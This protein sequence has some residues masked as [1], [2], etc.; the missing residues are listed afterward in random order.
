MKSV[1]IIESKFNNP[2]FNLAAEE[3]FLNNN[4]EG[5]Q[6]LF[7]WR[8]EPTIVV[9]KHQNPWVECDVSALERDNIHLARRKSGGG[10]VYQ[11]LGNSIF[12]FLSPNTSF[13]KER[14][15]S[16]LIDS[17]EL[18][19]VTGKCEVSGRNDIT[20]DGKKVSGSA[21]KVAEKNAIHH[22]TMLISAD[23]GALAKYLSP[24]KIKLEAK[25]VS[26]VRSRVTNLVE[27]AHPDRK[28]DH[29]AFC[30][31]LAKSFCTSYG[32][33]APE[34]EIIDES[35]L[36]KEPEIKRIADSLESWDWRFGST[37]H[38]TAVYEGR[39]DLGTLSVNLN[40]RNGII[41]DA[42]IFSDCLYTQFVEEL[43][44]D[45]K[46]A[47]KLE[48]VAKYVRKSQQNELFDAWREEF[49]NWF[50]SQL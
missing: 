34:I 16:I 23:L 4:P 25:G 29:E 3:F 21:Y 8:N 41:E 5:V 9:G 7:L 48:N 2:F 1:R 50:E 6:T 44:S 36:E 22:G 14:N 38:F 35:F 17:L 32:V 20:C 31:A 39:L 13:D 18:L 37:P 45:V 46:N 30:G 24:S 33:K 12:T 47:G 43:E 27:Y 49:I 28:I 26:S 40:M 11:D 42:K 15:N 10:A 19:G